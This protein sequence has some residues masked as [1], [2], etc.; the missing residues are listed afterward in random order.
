MC[1]VLMVILV[2]QI[3]G[4]VPATDAAHQMVAIKAVGALAVPWCHI[5][6]HLSALAS[7][8][9]A[10]IICNTAKPILV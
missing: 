6:L 10:V 1:K 4:S 9:Q 7:Q 8:P 2:V 3:R 5:C